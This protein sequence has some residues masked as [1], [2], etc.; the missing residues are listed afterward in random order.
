MSS[1]KSLPRAIYAATKALGVR[2]GMVA[3]AAPN[4]AHRLKCEQHRSSVEAVLLKITGA[5][6]KLV[7]SVDEKDDGNDD[8][9]KTSDGSSND[10]SSNDGSSNDGSS[11]GNVVQMKRPSAPPADEEVDLDGLVDAPPET[12][13]S[14]EDR[15]Q[16][17]FPGSQII[18]E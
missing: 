13:L 12:V 18:R 1:L 7:L 11:N 14:P 10:G 16:Q 17:A 3:I 6:V 8:A 15:L 5:Q 4:E 9:K 2:D